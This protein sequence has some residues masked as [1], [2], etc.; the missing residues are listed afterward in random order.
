MSLVPT[1]LPR[2]YLVPFVTNFHYGSPS[3]HLKPLKKRCFAGGM[4]ETCFSFFSSCLA[5]GF[6]LVCEISI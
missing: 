5:Y 4:K 2:C 3:H 1:Q 6:K